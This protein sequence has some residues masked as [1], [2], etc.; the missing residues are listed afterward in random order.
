MILDAG[1]VFLLH[2]TM[3][4]TYEKLVRN[5]IYDLLDPQTVCS[6]SDACFARIC[7][8]PP[9]LAADCFPPKHLLE[10]VLLRDLYHSRWFIFQA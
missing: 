4:R 1:N 10:M 9:I 7:V 3:A 6:L 8:P 5:V 2:A